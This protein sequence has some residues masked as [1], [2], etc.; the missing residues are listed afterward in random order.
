MPSSQASKGLQQ[1]QVTQRLDQVA[2]SL[3]VYRGFQKQG[4]L[5]DRGAPCTNHGSRHSRS[6]ALHFHGL[7]ETRAG[8]GRRSPDRPWD[9]PSARTG[10]RLPPLARPLLQKTL[11]HLLQANLNPD[12]RLSP[13][14]SIFQARGRQPQLPFSLRGPTD[15]TRG[16]PPCAGQASGLEPRFPGSRGKGAAQPSPPRGEGTAGRGA[17]G[18]RPPRH[19]P[20]VERVLLPELPQVLLLLLG[21]AAQQLPPA[22]PLPHAASAARPRGAPHAALRHAR[23]AAVALVPEP[24]SLPQV[25]SA[26][27]GEGGAV[28]HGWKVQ[29]G[30]FS[31]NSRC[32]ER[33]TPPFPFPELPAPPSGSP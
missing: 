30:M 31:A 9:G 18:S 1:H 16:R 17:R 7:G 23:R 12:F 2:H 22:P 19:S 20:V 25:V 15:T 3:R 33:P 5:F 14:L 4:T 6:A 8:C 11:R 27:S 24:R 26:A 10:A 32:A 13:V 29:T 21:Q 28:G